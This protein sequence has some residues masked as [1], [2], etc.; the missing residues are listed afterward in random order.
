MFRIRYP[1]I[2]YAYTLLLLSFNGGAAAQKSPIELTWSAGVISRRQLLVTPVQ[3]SVQG[4]GG[5]QVDLSSVGNRDTSAA[6]LQITSNVSRTQ[7]EFLSVLNNSS[8]ILTIE[9][10]VPGGT[11]GSTFEVPFL[12]ENGRVVFG[13]IRP[14]GGVNAD[15]GN[16]RLL[17]APTFSVQG[18][19]G[20]IRLHILPH[21]IGTTGTAMLRLKALGAVSILDARPLV[22]AAATTRSRDPV[23]ETVPFAIPVGERGL[24]EAEVTMPNLARGAG[25]RRSRVYLLAGRRR[26][27]SGTT[28]FST[29]E[30]AELQDER[31]SGG[32][33]AEEYQTRLRQILASGT[34]QT[35]K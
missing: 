6:V 15:A 9:S 20:Q 8:G 4:S 35:I 34:Q 23:A 25:F 31:S 19:S 13:S 16:F 3:L 11:T 17:A 2:A 7:Q 30:I 29:L 1:V 12:V 21:G 33:T 5:N 24:I 28:G 10:M 22:R 32:M 14:A 18:Y 26:L 27:Y